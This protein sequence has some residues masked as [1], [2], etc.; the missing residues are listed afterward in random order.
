MTT[1]KKD[2]FEF[3]YFGYKMKKLYILSYRRFG[4]FGFGG[5]LEV[6]IP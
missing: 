6:S 5:F 4:L 1:E 3:N 2:P